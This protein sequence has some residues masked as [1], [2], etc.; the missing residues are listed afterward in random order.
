MWPPF[1]SRMMCSTEAK[2]MSDV[3]GVVHG[4]HDAGGDLPTS[5]KIRTMPQIHI[6]L[7]FLGV[8]IISVS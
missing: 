8:R 7:R 4:E 5:A 6:Q 3:R 2:A 1:T